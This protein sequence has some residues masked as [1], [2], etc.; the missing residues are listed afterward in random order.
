MA[1]TKLIKAFLFL[2]L[3]YVGYKV[4]GAISDALSASF[5]NFPYIGVGTFIWI[6]YFATLLGL[7]YALKEAEL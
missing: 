1:A 7:G 2:L 3:A 4:F 6:T 5:T